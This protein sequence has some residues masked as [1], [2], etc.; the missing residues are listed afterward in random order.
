MPCSLHK[1]KERTHSLKF[2]FSLE[3]C[4]IVRPVREAGFVGFG[5]GSIFSVSP[6]EISRL[7]TGVAAP[8]VYM[9]KSS[10]PCLPFKSTQTLLAGAP[11]IL[12]L[13]P[14]IGTV[15]R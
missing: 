11:W 13:F 9:I 2:E 3:V 12:E 8:T 4:R 14:L 10:G 15:K 1:S 5:F 7:R 6:Q